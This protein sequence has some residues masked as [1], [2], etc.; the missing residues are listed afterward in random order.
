VNDEATSVLVRQL[1]R[2]TGV[3]VDWIQ[4]M[5]I[6]APATALLPPR[7]RYYGC[8][9]CLA[10]QAPDAMTPIWRRSWLLRVCWF[11]YD[12]AVPLIK[13]AA[14]GTRVGRPDLDAWMFL[15]DAEV[16]HRKLLAG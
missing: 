3:A 1:S 10:E 7:R 11:C 9:L 4:E 2:A 15:H 6:A 5:L 12:H 13:L 14:D 16:I 8:E